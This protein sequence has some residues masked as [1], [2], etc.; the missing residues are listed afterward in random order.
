METF[1]Y[2]SV[3][4]SIV[5]GLGVA[6]LLNNIGALI[7]N[8]HRVV[9][10]SVY[11]MHCA[12]TIL[13]MF[14]AWW[15]VFGYRNYPDW[16]FFF[17]LLIISMVSLIYLMTEM[18]EVNKDSELIDLDAN[19]MKN[20]RLFFLFFIV[21]AMCGAAVQSLVTD[22]SIFTRVNVLRVLIISFGLWGAFS[23][24]LKVQ[25]I[26]AIAFLVIFSAVIIGY[27]L[28]LGELSQ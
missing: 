15:T 8:K 9:H 24:S 4:I 2:I 13:L 11:Y 7:R 28:N 20:K 23:N 6:N 22:S 3:M 19:F 17:Y 16:D 14:Q 26:V 27:R 21:S 12:F 18:L 10:S 25:K 5:L 1:S